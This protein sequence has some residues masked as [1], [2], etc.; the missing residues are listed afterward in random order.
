MLVTRTYAPV[1]CS[2][3]N[4]GCPGFKTKLM[5]LVTLHRLL[6]VSDAS[7]AIRRRDSMPYSCRYKFA[8]FS[9]LRA[10]GS[11]EHIEKTVIFLVD[12]S[13]VA[14]PD[15]EAPAW[16]DSAAAAKAAEDEAVAAVKAAWKVAKEAK[17]VRAAGTGKTT[18]ACHQICPL[19]SLRSA[20]LNLPMNL[21]IRASLPPTPRNHHSLLSLDRLCLSVA[22]CSPQ[23]AL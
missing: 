13:S 12:P 20:Y 6:C 7:L 21:R 5:Y 2:M 1:R 4:P 16:D 11:I 22:A 9:Y 8:E 23:L 3:L 18:H 17:E 10:A 15:S 14:K 19:A